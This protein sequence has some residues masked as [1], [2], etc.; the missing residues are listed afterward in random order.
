[1][2]ATFASLFPE[3]TDWS[4]LDERK[5][6]LSEKAQL[7]IDQ[8]RERMRQRMLQQQERASRKRSKEVLLQSPVIDLTAG[9]SAAGHSTMSVETPEPRVAKKARVSAAA[10]RDSPFTTPGA[11]SAGAGDSRFFALVKSAG[12]A[13]LRGR[14]LPAR[15]E[16][17]L[18]KTLTRVDPVAASALTLANCLTDAGYH[19][20]YDSLIEQVADEVTSAKIEKAS[21]YHG[22]DDGVD[23]ERDQDEEV[24]ADEA[25]SQSLVD[26]WIAEARDEVYKMAWC[27]LCGYVKSLF[28]C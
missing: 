23:D 17:P 28:L 19:A 15:F 9:D 24:G 8:Q 22:E 5:R 3:C 14:I 25:L 12:L 6:E 10:G 20:S 21:Q 11:S 26:E 7:N 13:R 1:M 2:Q 18:L 4:W 27:F 16:Q